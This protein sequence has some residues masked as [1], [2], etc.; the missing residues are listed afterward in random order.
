MS[1]TVPTASAGLSELLPPTSLVLRVR[2]SRVQT[3]SRRGRENVFFRRKNILGA[4]QEPA[5]WQ[6]LG[7]GEQGMA[8]AFKNHL[9]Q[10]SDNYPGTTVV[11]QQAQH[12]SNGVCF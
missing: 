5:G 9:L 3:W 1:R 2:V 11:R 8:S 7:T 10:Q 12:L 6:V 4:F